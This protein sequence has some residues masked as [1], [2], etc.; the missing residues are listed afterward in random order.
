MERIP[1]RPSEAPFR[2]FL[3]P[4][5]KFKWD[6]KG[7]MDIIDTIK[8]GVHIFDPNLRTCVRTDWSKEGMGYYLSQKLCR[9]DLLGPDCCEEGWRICLAGSQ[10][11]YDAESTY[12]PIEGEVLAVAW[13][14]EQSKFFMQGCDKLVVATDHKPLVGLLMDRSLDQVSNARLLQIKQRI[15]LW[16]FEVLH[17]P[18]KTNYF[19]NGRPYRRTNGLTDETGVKKSEEK[20]PQS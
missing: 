9:C 18:G 8:N 11:N 10:F 15:S 3:S 6:E 2:P 19:A 1:Q 14:L 20:A 16:K 7:K 5:V 17:I 4:K 13:A 12:A